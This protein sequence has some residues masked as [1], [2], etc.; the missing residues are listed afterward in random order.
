MSDMIS[1]VLM[2]VLGTLTTLLCLRLKKWREQEKRKMIFAPYLDGEVWFSTGNNRDTYD[3]SLGVR[4][5]EAEFVKSLP[6]KKMPALGDP[7]ALVVR[8]PNMQGALRGEAH[9][10]RMRCPMDPQPPHF[11]QFGSFLF[12]ESYGWKAR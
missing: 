12:A 1:Y 2:F 5:L 4:Y 9:K 3:V 6:G 7:A 8:I 10:M 11:K